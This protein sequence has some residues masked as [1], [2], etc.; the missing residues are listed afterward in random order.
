[1][2]LTI[3][4]ELPYI[5]IYN[6]NNNNKKRIGGIKDLNNLKKIW[7]SKVNVGLDVV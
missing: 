7:K 6:K 2:Y 5:Y 1:M 4:Q 3:Y